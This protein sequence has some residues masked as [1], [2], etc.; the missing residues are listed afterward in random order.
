L[1]ESIIEPG[2]RVDDEG[3]NHKQADFLPQPC[4]GNNAPRGIHESFGI[5]GHYLYDHDKASRTTTRP[6]VATG[7]SLRSHRCRRTARNLEPRGR[8][9]HD[10]EG[11]E[12]PTTTSKFRGVSARSS[13]PSPP[14][15]QSNPS[16]QGIDITDDEQT[17]LFSAA[18]RDRVCSFA[19]LHTVACGR[20]SLRLMR[21]TS[22]FSS[23]CSPTAACW[24]E[25]TARIA[26]GG[27]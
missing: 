2:D 26:G 6:F 9:H 4:L 15:R 11:G 24:T 16:L 13:P 12:R 19:E 8:S 5:T 25:V 1:L 10:T 21:S 18:A 22:C 3:D 14:P 27:L 23:G 20:N 7:R 17:A